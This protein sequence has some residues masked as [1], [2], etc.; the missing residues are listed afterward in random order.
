M[1]ILILPRKESKVQQVN[2]GGREKPAGMEEQKVKRT[3]ERGVGG[4]EGRGG[5]CGGAGGISEQ[6]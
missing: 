6:E 5:D 4:G 3:K 2:G 1:D